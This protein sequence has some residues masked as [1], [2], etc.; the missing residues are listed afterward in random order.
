MDEVNIKQL[1]INP[2]NTG[3]IHVSGIL[4]EGTIPLI[5]CAAEGGGVEG[6]FD[7]INPIS[8]AITIASDG[9]PLTSFYHY[10][11]FIAKDNVIIGYPINNW[12]FTTNLFIVNQINGLK[13]RF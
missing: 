3:T 8:N 10:Y 11:P 9:A 1:F 2:I 7:L 5:S 12:K 13:W 6:Y 4:D